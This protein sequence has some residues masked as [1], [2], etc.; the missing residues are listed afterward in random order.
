MKKL[1]T[2][3][4]V[5]QPVIRDRE[6]A[7]HP[8]RRVL[9]HVLRQERADGLAVDHVGDFGG[10]TWKTFEWWLVVGRGLRIYGSLRC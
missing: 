1:A 9:V 2:R 4:S 10:D 7:L 6:E 5:S 3:L 8:V